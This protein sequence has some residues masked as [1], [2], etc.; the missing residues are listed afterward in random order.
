[1]YISDIKENENL[2]S[3]II[4]TILNKNQALVPD[5]ISFS[6]YHHNLVPDQFLVQPEHI[7]LFHR[8]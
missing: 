6:I 4:K 1:M 2:V 5:F 3:V 7:L 8:D